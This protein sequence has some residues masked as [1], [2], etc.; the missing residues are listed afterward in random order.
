MIFMVTIQRVYKVAGRQMQFNETWSGLA[1]LLYLLVLVLFVLAFCS[2]G[3]G[4]W[5]CVGKIGL[6]YQPL[7]LESPPASLGPCIST[8]W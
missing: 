4:V 3:S 6:W 7:R 2:I 8:L 5:F 1:V